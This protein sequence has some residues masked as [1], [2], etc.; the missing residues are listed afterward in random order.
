VRNFVKRLPTRSGDTVDL[1]VEEYGAEEAE[2]AYR[3]CTEWH[4]RVQPFI[5]YNSARPDRKWHW[6]MIASLM[7]GSGSAK[8]PKI[9]MLRARYATG[10]APAGMVALL[11]NEDWVANTEQSSVF[12]WY[13][14][15]TPRMAFPR[16]VEIQEGLAPPRLLGRATLD[17]AVTVAID[18]EA[19]GR[20]WL[21]ASGSASSA[22]IAEW[23]TLENGMCRLSAQAI[24]AL[25]AAPG[26]W[27]ANRGHCFVHTPATAHWAHA[28]MNEWR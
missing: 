21:A 25:P 4:E 12:V 19:R 16:L 11:E 26:L 17:A 1:D 8:A 2:A 9:F 28:A 6:P 27:R 10:S 24:P 20:L 13:L 5:R 23:C 7:F 3:A 18:A 15:T 14:A 22:G